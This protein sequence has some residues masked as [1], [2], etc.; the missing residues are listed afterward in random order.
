V[1]TPE[2]RRTAVTWAMTTT[3]LSQRTA[4][5]FTGFARAADRYRSVRPPRA[6]LRARLI[7]LAAERARWATGAYID[8]CAAKAGR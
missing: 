8:C 7:M 1:V 4:C 3:D 5:R 2:Q 6:E